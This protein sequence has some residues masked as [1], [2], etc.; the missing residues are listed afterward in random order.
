MNFETYAYTDCGSRKNNEDNLI[1]SEDMWVV[2]DGLGGHGGGE[3]ASQAATGYIMG[4][5]KDTPE[6]LTDNDFLKN[7]VEGA[8]ARILELQKT[9]PDLKQMRTT[10]VAVFTDSKVLRY[11]NVG[12]S[13]FYYFKKG[14]LF[15]QSK[16]HSLS[17]VSVKMGSITD[18]RL[19]VD[20]NK[21]LR[22]LGN[23]EEVGV[24]I[25]EEVIIPEPGDTFLLC[26]DGFWEYVY[27]TEME[28][29]LAKSITMEQWM[30]FMVK[31]ILLKTKNI[32]NDNFTAICVKVK[33]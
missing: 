16:D 26:S 17:A 14:K 15:Y 23:S 25:P 32:S 19:D 27:E 22:A 21:L 9:T 1:Y 12:D 2:C 11:V 7:V 24:E 28:I 13:R 33:M 29:D 10:V 20:R 4:M 30:K 8:N 5:V 3:K 18:V 31:R 6:K